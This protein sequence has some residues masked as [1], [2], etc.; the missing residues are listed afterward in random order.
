M[1]TLTQTTREAVF[2][3]QTGEAFLALVT[4]D[5]PELASPVRVSSDSTDTPSRGETFVAFP[6]RITLP[7]DSAERPPRARLKIDNV[8]RTI[9]KKLRAISSAPT[10][11]IEIVRGDDPDTVEASFPDFKLRDAGYDVLE[12]EGDLDLEDFI[13]EPYPAFI[14]SPAHFPALF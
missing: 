3:S 6:F 9:V 11:L 13:S 4:L 2:A 14:F 1:R 8:D 5:H 7:E 12:V 10:V